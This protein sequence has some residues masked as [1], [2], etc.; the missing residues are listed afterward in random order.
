MGKM[1]TAKNRSHMAQM[2][3]MKEMTKQKVMLL[4][5]TQILLV[6]AH[7]QTMMMTLFAIGIS[8]RGAPGVKKA[9]STAGFNFACHLPKKMDIYIHMNICR[10]IQV[11]ALNDA[12]Q[13][14]RRRIDGERC[15]TPY[16][17]KTEHTVAGLLI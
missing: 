5:K 4:M 14:G 17:K 3:R 8:R 16:G 12:T 10:Q 7:Q 11:A 1:M 13:G 9:W 6:R 15:P 2:S